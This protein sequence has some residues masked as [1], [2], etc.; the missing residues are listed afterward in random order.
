MSGCG[1]YIETPEEFS[2]EFQAVTTF[3][4]EEAQ[5]TQPSYGEN[6]AAYLQRLLGIGDVES[7]STVPSAPKT[8]A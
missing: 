4:A 8:V 1:D 2:R 7:P 3:L 6:C 5:G